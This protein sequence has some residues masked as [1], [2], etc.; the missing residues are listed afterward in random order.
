MNILVI[1]CGSSSIKY[2]L[3]DMENELVLTKGAAE[4]IG[5][6]GSKIEHKTPGKGEILIEEDMEDHTIAMKYILDAIVDEEHGAITSMDEIKAV[7]HRVVHGGEE[8]SKSV[9]I[10]DK[11]MKSLNDCIELAPLHNPSNIMGIEVCREIMPDTP[12]VCV[13]DTAFHQTMDPEAYIYAVPYEYYE[14]HSVRRY[15]FH[16]T[17]HKYIT[18][19]AAKILGKDVED[20]NLITCHL[21]NGSSI[22]GIKNGESKVTSMGFTPLAGLAMGTRSGDIDPAIV[23]FIM[24]KEGLNE[25]EMNEVLN[26]KS[27][28]LGISGLSSDFR[29]LELASKDGNERAELALNIFVHD[30]K[31][32]IGAYMALIGEIDALIFTAGIG[33]NS[34][35]IRREVCSGLEHL[36]INIDNEKNDGIRGKEA[37]IQ[38]DDSDIKILVIPTDEELMIAQ[39]TLELVK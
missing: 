4:R 9:L 12:M 25:E 22:S 38:K 16:G 29:D 32:Y 8:F 1:N 36:G 37:F 6:E 5:I 31:K 26:K 30:V 3:L 34:D 33:E 27:G 10:D 39:E 23:P 20:V 18:E 24:G 15:G 17:S 11:V 7:G 21:G 28:V 2:Q 13:F 35:Y 19:R 14:D